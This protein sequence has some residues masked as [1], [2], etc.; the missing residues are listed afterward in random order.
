MMYFI[1]FYY[2][3]FVVV[4]ALIK[5]VGK[6]TL[7]TSRERAA[8]RE[9]KRLEAESKLEAIRRTGERIRAERDRIKNNCK[10]GNLISK[11]LGY[12]YDLRKKAVKRFGKDTPQ[13]V[14]IDRWIVEKDS[15]M[16]QL[17]ENASSNHQD[18]S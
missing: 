4:I 8:S 1:F 16:K 5:S 12:L 10:M 3:L 18:M 15:L 11:R 17:L 2:I 7:S 13:V 9:R 6:P 14:L